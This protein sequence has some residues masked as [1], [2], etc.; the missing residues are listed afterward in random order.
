[1]DDQCSSGATLIRPSG[2]TLTGSICARTAV[3]VARS[4]V[5]QTLGAVSRSARAKGSSF[6]SSVKAAWRGSSSAGVG[7]STASRCARERRGR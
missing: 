4:A 3:S 5:N 2:L 1:L 6:T 7:P